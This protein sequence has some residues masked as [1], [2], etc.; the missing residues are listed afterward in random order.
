MMIITQGYTQ[1]EVC[2]EDARIQQE[3]ELDYWRPVFLQP[4]NNA[5]IDYMG[6]RLVILFGF[7]R[8]TD[9]VGNLMLIRLKTDFGKFLE[10]PC[11]KDAAFLLAQVENIMLAFQQLGIKL[12]NDIMKSLKRN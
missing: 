8:P 6:D 10:D 1:V 4:A 7:G 9:P 3:L 12:E 11:S 2:M 5:R